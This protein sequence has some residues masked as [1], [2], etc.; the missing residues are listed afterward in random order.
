MQL[1][2]ALAL[3]CVATPAQA[4]RAHATR[5]YSLNET[6]HL[7]RTSGRGITINQQLNEQGSASGTIPGTIYIHLKVVSVNRVTAEVNIYPSGGSITASASASYRSAGAVASFTGT[8]DIVRGTGRYN[9]AHGSGLQ[10]TGT[11]QRINDAI[12]VHV[13]GSMY[14]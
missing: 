4:A 12:T 10:F 2:L 1:S 6:G 13:T 14:T 3:A 9:G 5:T 11:V 7:H 8:I